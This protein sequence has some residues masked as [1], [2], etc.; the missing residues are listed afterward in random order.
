MQKKKQSKFS[1]LGLTAGGILLVTVLLF[2]ALKDDNLRKA[3]EDQTSQVT[4]A[5]VNEDK[6]AKFENRQYIL[7]RDFVTLINN[8]LDHNWQTTT[9]SVA[10]AGI[11]D[12]Q[13]DA[14]IYIPQNFSERLLDL[15]SIAPDQAVVDYQVSEG[16]NELTN[17][18]VQI[19]VDSILKEFNQRIVQ[20]YFSSIVGN[21]SEAQRN[22][23]TIVQGDKETHTSLANNIQSPFKELPGNFS[24]VLDVSS[25]LD[26]D[27][28]RFIAEQKSF[29]DSVQQLLDTNNEGLNSSSESLEKNKETVDQFTEDVNKKIEESIQQFNDQVELQKKQLAAQWD[30]DLTNYQAQFDG[31]NH[32]LIQQM[33]NFY[34]SDSTT[35]K[36]T[37]VLADFY[38]QAAYFQENQT[39]RMDE[40]KNEIDQLKQQV[41]SLKELRTRIAETYYA[42]GNKTPDDS[43]LEDTKQAILNLTDLTSSQNSSNLKDQYLQVLNGKINTI[44]NNELRTWLD[45]LVSNGKL[46]D[47]EANRYKQEL[48]VIEEY[49][50]DYGVSFSTGTNFKYLTTA[51]E[52][53][54]ANPVEVE[55]ACI[56]AINPRTIK[57]LDLVSVSNVEIKDLG[58]LAATVKSILD[59]ELS[60]YDYETTVTA[61][62]P[63]SLS[64][65]VASKPGGTTPISDLPKQIGVNISPTIQWTLSDTELKEAF[66][67][68]EYSWRVNGAE[69]NKGYYASF[70]DKNQPLVE[71]LPSIF[72]QFETLGGSAQQIM[73][74]FADP[75][76]QG[77]LPGFLALIQDPANIGRPLEELATSESIYNSYDNITDEAKKKLI[78]DSLV[79]EYR[80]GG[81]KLYKQVDQQIKELRQTIGT[82]KNAE[83][84]TNTL[85]STLHFM[86]L[87]EMLNNEANK[88]NQWFNSANEQIAATYG[89]WKE[90]EKIQT[91]S[92][93][94]EE[95]PH[96]ESGDTKPIADATASV[97]DTMK[98]LVETAKNSAES[99][100]K[101]AAEVE[102][103]GSKIEDI[104]KTTKDVQG[105]ADKVLNNLDKVVADANKKDSTN[106]IYSKNFDKVLTNTRQGGADNQKV[107]NFLASPMNTIGEF[108]ENR[109][110]SAVPYY[111]TFIGTIVALFVG[112]GLSSSLFE[113][114][115]RDHDFFVTQSRLWKNTP[116]A[117]RTLIISMIIAIFV[118]GITAWIVTVNSTLGW[119]SYTFLV[120]LISLLLTTALARQFGRVGLFIVGLLFGFYLMMTPLL[121]MTTTPGSVIHF[122]FRI[123]PM[124]NIENG[125]TAL[126]N[127][128]SIGW[129]TYLFLIVLT[130]ISLGL[131]FFVSVSK[132]TLGEPLGQVIDHE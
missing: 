20:M 78:Q 83:N 118:S 84:E 95:N 37:G 111:L 16:Q 76:Q 6:G 131:N 91:E 24:S 42:D 122:I 75:N 51:G 44:N 109:T 105:N 58:A 38:G 64:I 50:E 120:F 86:M 89:S 19:K 35:K 72:A 59:N 36:N 32:S 1:L 113:R 98:A 124:Q 104:T 18:A 73:T 3:A 27:N 77:D 40:I 130:L 9:R 53:P 8:D 46:S 115:L 69:Q 33:N 60:Q 117:L 88:L 17:Q 87:P 81:D 85:Y 29:V 67:E 21:L 132:D 10:E 7:G 49:A 34:Q 90:A 4:Y 48:S 14:V 25:I 26:A 23:N 94:N 82:E 79:K 101:S 123:S 31:L 2:F 62:P 70:A 55:Q 96:P 45:L 103:V 56:V 57:S 110:I 13:F 11:I 5:L 28:K 80:A 116:N 125:Y 121:G 66:V 15:Q 74:L 12:G 126:L 114:K 129:G 65:S 92:I 68:L 39:A 61:G 108:G 102:D 30:N 97:S 128:L 47:S 43:T 107:F 99:T 106:D 71:D 52:V 100:N 112:Y 93:I 63:N 127:G 119:F 54:H 22:V 41:E